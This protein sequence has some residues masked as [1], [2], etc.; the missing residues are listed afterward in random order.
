MNEPLIFGSKGK[1][2]G[3]GPLFRFS[4]LAGINSDDEIDV[5]TVHHRST[6]QIA[7]S[8]L[9]FSVRSLFARGQSYTANVV[10][11]FRLPARAGGCKGRKNCGHRMHATDTGTYWYHIPATAVCC[12]SLSI[13]RIA[14]TCFCRHR[15]ENG[16]CTNSMPYHVRRGDYKRSLLLRREDP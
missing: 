12:I 15:I 13:C 10:L 8:K 16:P 2:P 9:F 7:K 4:M 1:E 5:H 11:L 3:S 14:L 6:R